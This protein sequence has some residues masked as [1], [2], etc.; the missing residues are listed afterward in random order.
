MVVLSPIRTSS[1]LFDFKLLYLIQHFKPKSSDT[2]PVEPD[3][4]PLFGPSFNQSEISMV[5]EK[6][7]MLIELVK[8]AWGK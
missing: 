5:L 2:S 8:P 4:A 6:T 7:I 1:V 3:A